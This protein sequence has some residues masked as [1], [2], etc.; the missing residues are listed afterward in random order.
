M[1]PFH[2][3]WTVVVAVGVV[4]AAAVW[5]GM[6]DDWIFA[7]NLLGHC[8]GWFRTF[9]RSSWTRAGTVSVSDAAAAGGG[10]CPSEECS[11]LIFGNDNDD[12]VG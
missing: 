3:N 6:K 8:A 10:L 2:S 11:W 12:D 1:T 4:V 5:T 7:G 9:R